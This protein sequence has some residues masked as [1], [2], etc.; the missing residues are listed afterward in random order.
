MDFE[1]FV[2]ETNKQT[3]PDAVFDLFIQAVE[4]FGFDRIVFSLLTDHPS[5][6]FAAGHGIANNYP[7]DWMDY[8]LSKNY[9]HIDPVPKQAFKSGRA[10]SWE[11]LRGQTKLT[12][13]ESL[14]MHEAEEAELKSGVGIPLYGVGMEIAGFGLASTDGGIEITKDLLSILQA[15]A[16]QFHNAYIDLIKTEAEEQVKLTSREREVLLWMAEGKTL[17]EI[18]MILNVGEET[19][20]YYK[21][22]IFSKLKANQQTLAVL[23]AIR[24]GVINP[25]KLRL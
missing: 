7:D 3:S 13:E 23:K 9:Q 4:E 16:R 15:Y 10:F 20:R 5:I 8:Y 11:D 21:K 14:V 19:I 2:S 12:K 17:P 1:R 22:L 24:A 18:A 6:G 25:Y